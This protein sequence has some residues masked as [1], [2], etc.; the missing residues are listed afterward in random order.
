MPRQM[1]DTLQWQSLSSHR[2]FDSLPEPAILVDVDGLIA[3]GNQCACELFETGEPFPV[4]SV[5][6]L[7]TEPERERLQVLSWFKKWADSPA[8]PE[9]DYVYLSVRTKS[10]AEKQLSARVSR[11]RIKQHTAGTFETFYLVTMHDIGPWE[12]RLRRER[13]AHRIAARV[14]ALSADA[15]LVVDEQSM[16][17][18]ANA[19]ADVLFCCSKGTLLARPLADLIPERYR[20]SHAKLMQQFSQETSPSRYMSDRAPIYALT[21]QGNEVLV[22]ASITRI[23]LQNRT[24]F[25]VH[26]RQ[27]QDNKP[28][29]LIGA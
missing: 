10:A 24:L 15:V 8:A 16:V 22:E 21:T 23:N 7:L 1:S 20:S 5:N 3:A 18:Y 27:R 11:V 29:A 26:L 28:E 25:S 9:L 6:E 13:E 14:L 4:I 17:T 12:Q 19:S 2:L